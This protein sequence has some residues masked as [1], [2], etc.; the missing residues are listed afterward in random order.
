MKDDN[1]TE[2]RLILEYDIEFWRYL[3]YFTRQQFHQY[4]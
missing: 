2:Q 3:V 1:F 4:N